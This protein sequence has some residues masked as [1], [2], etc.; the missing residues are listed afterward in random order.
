MNTFEQNPVL[1]ENLRRLKS[2]APVTLCKSWVTPPLDRRTGYT[3][4]LIAYAK[5]IKSQAT[6]L[7]PLIIVTKTVKNAES[8]KHLVGSEN[9][10]VVYVSIVNP[11]HLRGMQPLAI[12]IDNEM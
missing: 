4:K 10:W 3:S 11:L 8:I 12:L 6:K 5:T 9:P 2:M 7:N 1:R